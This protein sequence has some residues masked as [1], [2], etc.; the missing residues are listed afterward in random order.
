MAKA[1]DIG[2]QNV[3]TSPYLCRARLRHLLGVFIWDYV[4]TSFTGV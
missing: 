3:E 4:E 1:W 2:G